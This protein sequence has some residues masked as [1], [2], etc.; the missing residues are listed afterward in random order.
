MKV[1]IYTLGNDVVLDQILA[2]LNSIEATVGP[3]MPVCI[4]PY[5][6]QVDALRA[7][8]SSRPQVSLFD[9]IATI[10]KWD[11]YAKAIWDVHPTAHQRWQAAGSQG[12]HR[13]GTHRRFC[14][15]DGPFE[16]FI[17][18]DADTLLLDQ[19]SDV[20]QQL[21][22]H[23][24]VVY[25]FQ[26]KDPSHVY[27]VQSSRL[28]QVFSPQQLQTQIFCSGFYATR[29][30]IFSDTQLAELLFHLQNGDA[31]ILYSQAPDQTILN[32]MVMKSDLRFTNLALQRPPDRVTGNSVT[33]PHFEIRDHIVYDR[34]KRLQY[35]HYIGVSSKLFK[36]VCQG[37]NWA[38]PYRDVFLHY[39][40]RHA[41]AER[42]S[43]TGRPQ[44]YQP[45]LTRKQRFKQRLF[46]ALGR[47]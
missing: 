18:M 40:Y 13:L 41:P 15:F 32:Y 3:D 36:R 31:E 17:Y 30:Q 37:E 2:L 33:S 35:L 28:Y 25:D 1:G 38:I 10:Q 27:D 23:D 4:C 19:V 26:H 22:T 43:L 29:R 45:H 46:R 16:A 11:T 6:D 5:D 12:Y 20:F 44:R 47:A 39:R 34:G 7:A 21:E 8:I 42:P 14:G 9:D 24:W